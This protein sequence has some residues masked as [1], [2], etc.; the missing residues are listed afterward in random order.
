ML[1]IKSYFHFL[2]NPKLNLASTKFKNSSKVFIV[3]LLIT[4]CLVF[5]ASLIPSNQT[6]SSPYTIKFNI[7]D[8][9]LLL[10]MIPIYEELLFRFLLKTSSLNI[11]ISL[12]L[13]LSSTLIILFNT[14]F[15]NRIT[16]LEFHFLSIIIAFPI[17]AFLT[18]KLNQKKNTSFLFNEL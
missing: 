2:L 7:N 3:V 12:G 11:S 16:L 6:I 1:I 17:V 14:I 5:L 10:L 15:S 18:L 9:P 4:Y 13:C 8:A